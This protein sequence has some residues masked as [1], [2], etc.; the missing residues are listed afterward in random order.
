MPDA[1]LHLRS[2]PFFAIYVQVYKYIYGCVCIV[3]I[4]K[5]EYP[6]GVQF[7]I[8]RNI[9]DILLYFFYDCVIY[10]CNQNANCIK[11]NYIKII[12]IHVS[13]TKQWHGL[14]FEMLSRKH[15]KRWDGKSFRYI[16][17]FNNM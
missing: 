16:N 10:S 14:F 12:K 8:N 3:N 9:I 13:T 7:I 15:H 1:A 5:Y 2:F 17:M 6:T 11:V 4:Y